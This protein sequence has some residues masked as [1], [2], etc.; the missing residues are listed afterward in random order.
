M[1]YNN[2]G[3]SRYTLK[4]LLEIPELQHPPI[5]NGHLDSKKTGVSSGYGIPSAFLGPT[6]LWNN[7][8]Q[9]GG[10]ENGEFSLQYMDLDEF[11]SE[12]G[13]P[14]SEL[15]TV[16][17]QCAQSPQ[18]PNLAVPPSENYI[19]LQTPPT[20][21]ALSPGLPPKRTS[22]NN[23]PRQVYE[24]VHETSAPTFYSNEG[25]RSPS[26]PYKCTESSNGSSVS[27]QSTNQSCSNDPSAQPVIAGQ[28][29]FDPRKCKFSD[30]ELKPQPII[31]KSRKVF[32]PDACKDERYWMRR[33]KNNIAAK[34]SREARRIKENQIALR[35][36][37][38]EKENNALKDEVNKIKEENV[39]LQKK[40]SQYEQVGK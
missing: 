23:S 24:D 3:D 2:F 6:N 9:I 39:N 19:Q 11:L 29:N 14:S 30:E 22:P 37:F 8:S 7:A 4:N 15:N 18:E 40:L 12:N 27:S 38:L 25:L 13:I 5:L 36:A 21:Q 33:T 26:S 34:R 17:N 16:N 32:V 31:R 35:A 10:Q 1:A 28:E 20:P